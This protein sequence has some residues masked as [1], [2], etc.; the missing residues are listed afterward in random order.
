M[1]S[2]SDSNTVQKCKFSLGLVTAVF[3]LNFSAYRTLES[4]QSSINP[5]VGLYALCALYAA[6]LISSMFLPPLVLPRF[7][8][9]KI[10]ACSLVFY[11]LYTAGKSH[12]EENIFQ[13]C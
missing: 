1:I 4:L 10:L 7:Q 3:T 11:T 6:Y 12:G 9:G 8:T 13:A 2:K 5:E